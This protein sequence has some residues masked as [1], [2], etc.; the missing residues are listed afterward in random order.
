MLSYKYRNGQTGG[1]DM[2]PV[3]KVSGLKKTFQQVK[4]V[5]GIDFQVE[6]GELFGFLGVNGAGKSTDRKSVV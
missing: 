4:A 1:D 3:I 5:D 2:E 6:Q